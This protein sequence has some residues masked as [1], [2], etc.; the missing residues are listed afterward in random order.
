MSSTSATNLAAIIPSKHGRLTI[1]TRDIP[2]PGP[3]ELLVRN[4]AIAGN[5]VDWKIQ[6]YGIFISTYPTV[7][8][9]DVAGIVVSVG[10]SVTHFA[11]GDRVIGFSAVVYNDNADHGAWQTYTLLREVGASKLPA[12]MTF[13]QGSIFPMAMA[14]A[15]IALFVILG[16]PQALA[17]GEAV[18]K[19]SSAL[20][21]W[22]A[23]SSVGVSAVQLA[24]SMGLTVFATASPQHHG[25][26]KQLGVAEVLDY[27]DRDVVAKLVEAAKARGTTIDL[28]FDPISEGATFDQVSATVEAAGGKGKGKVATTLYW[29]EGKDKPA[30]VQVDVTIAMRHGTDQEKLGRWF[31]N[32]WLERAMEDGTV[33][34]APQIEIVEG[35]VG[36]APK[37]FE[38]LKKGV[39]GKKLVVQLP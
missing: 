20:L 29:P 17:Q 8:G 13:E 24:Q 38:M 7:L 27:H 33:V 32:E 22:G 19:P 21:I 5:P 36:A 3:G 10:P 11:P 31:F 35:G 23:A 30:D 14:T 26:L 28:A 25:W 15:A 39:S 1:S 34:P 2:T 16:I 12:S 37:L 4:H 9:S 18:E 6:D